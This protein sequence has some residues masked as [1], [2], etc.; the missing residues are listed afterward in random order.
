MKIKRI[1][2]LGVAVQDL[3]TAM[4]FFTDSLPLEVTH[5]EDFNGMKIAF[6]P[7]GDSS[8]ELLQDVS[9]ASA[10]KKF[11][12]KNGEGIHHIAYEVDDINEAIAE[13]KAKGIKLIDETP[14][15]GAHGMSVAFMHPKA[16]HGILMELCQP[17][18]EPH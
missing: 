12:D 8:V 4:K 10:I 2:H 1:A 17:S 13:L 6:I 16:T 5:T 7:I 18:V 11:V 9:G 14:R 3:E 15:Q